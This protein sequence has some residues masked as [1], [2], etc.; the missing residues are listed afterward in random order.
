M[1]NLLLTARRRIQRLYRSILLLPAFAL[2]LLLI[3]WTGAAY[4]VAQERQSA[5]NDAVA[6]SQVLARTLADHTNAILRQVDHATQL[7]KLQYEAGGGA[8]R[9]PEFTRRNGLLNSVLPS[10]LDLPIAL[11]GADGAIVDSVNGYPSASQAGEDFFRRHAGDSADT[12]LAGTPL[13]DAAAHRW[14]I[15]ISRRLNDARGRFAGAIAIMVDPAYFVDDYDRLS[16][17]DDGALL[18]ASRDTGLAIGRIGETIVQSDSIDFIAPGGGHPPEELAL[19]QPLDHIE[20]LYSGRELPRYALLSIVG[21]ARADALVKFERHRRIYFGALAA[22]T[23]LIVAFVGLLMRQS[24]RLRD[25]MHE[26][27]EAQSMLRAAADGSLDSVL[28]L[29]AWPPAPRDAAR[30]GPIEDFVCADLNQRAADLLQRPR[31]AIRGQKICA[32]F[33]VLRQPVF[34]DKYVKVLESGQ[35]L[36]DEFQHRRTDG[37]MMWLHHQ[38]VAIDDGVAV[39][40]RDITARK[41]DELA[42]RNHEAEL[43]AVN[44]ASPLGLA[45]SDC[46][47]R[48]TYVNRTFEA[49]TGLERDAALGYG[50][51]RAVHRD[52]RRILAPALHHLRTAGEPFQA[53]L[54]CRHRDGKIVWVSLKIAAI[55]VDGAIRGYVGSIDDITSLHTS[56]MALLES[57]ARLRTIADTVPAMIAYIDAGQIYRFHNAAYEKEFGQY[58]LQI[59]HTVRDAVGE[60]HYANLQPYIARVLAGETLRFEEDEDCQGGRRCMEVNYIPQYSK[61][62]SRVIGFHVMR[63]DITVQKR[64]KQRLLKLA[65]VD[66]LTGLTNRAGFLQKLSEAMQLTKENGSMMAVM[67]MD[68]DRFKPVNDTHGHSVGDALLKAFSARLTHTM[69]TSDTIARLGGDEFTII[70]ENVSRIEDANVRAARIVG[71]MQASFDLDGVKVG[72]SASIGVTFYRDEDIGPA[73]LLKEADVLLYRAKQAGRNTYRSATLAELAAGGDAA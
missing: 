15:R 33:P 45:R 50:W 65:Q 55:V 24:Q 36:E 48:C 12:P 42:L 5:L 22:A 46:Q 4:R 37:D 31:E 68:I 49:I 69:R 28:L 23:L 35:T 34:F 71:A 41:N 66:A 8:L 18:L 14:V 32:L 62:G 72:V 19:R 59:G 27:R 61:D 6:H 51:L 7:F 20:R 16:V 57:E 70:M 10:K 54:R 47:G 73:A 67:Y 56:E 39:T 13:L 43:A 25:S 44:D 63:Q 64:E 60:S 53:A 17:D 1:T 29:K 11:I 30:P 9:L 52:D 2:V 3:L 40:S 21:V 26:A 38:I 58:A